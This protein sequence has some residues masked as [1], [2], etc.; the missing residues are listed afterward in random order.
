MILVVEGWVGSGKRDA[1]RTLAA[2]W[3]PC[4]LTVRCDPAEGA[5]DPR[6]W[7]APYWAALPTPATTTVYFRSWYRRLIDEKLA[8]ALTERDWIRRLDEVNEFES[9]Q[10][11]HGTTIVKLFFHVDAATQ[12]E[13]LRARKRDPW[14]TGLV[15]DDDLAG[16]QRREVAVAA[17]E[18]ALGQTDTRWAPWR[19]IDANDALASR[20]AMLEAVA[21][22][23]DKAMPKDPPQDG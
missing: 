10:H 18:D 7:L 8:G 2:A 6:H 5:S 13:R 21:G 1:L 20:V 12:A 23:M 17:I 11:D 4:Q 14:L 3:D 9:Q 22:A 15:T 16:L 19:V